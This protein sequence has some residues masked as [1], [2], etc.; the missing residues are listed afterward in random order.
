MKLSIE[1][2][3]QRVALEN[4]KEEVII[5]LKKDQLSQNE[6]SFLKKEISKITKKFS[7]GSKTLEHILSIQI[8]YNKSGLDCGGDE[9]EKKSFS[10]N[11]RK[12]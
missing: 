5:L 4:L 2:I 1:N 12:D 3:S 7:L 11:K 6:N 8:L 10:K 9:E